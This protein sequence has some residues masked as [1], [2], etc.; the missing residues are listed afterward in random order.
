[1]TNE[2]LAIQA[3]TGDRDALARLWE[4]NRGLLA[5]MFR[6]LAGKAGAR[7]SAIGVTW[8]DVEQFLLPCNLARCAAV[9]A[10]KRY[11]VCIVPVLSGQAGIL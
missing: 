1:M 4:Q 9:Q 5:T 6:E 3:K 7:M 2:E 11:T 8:E 10:G